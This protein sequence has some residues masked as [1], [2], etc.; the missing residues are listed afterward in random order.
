V[1]LGHRADESEPEPQAPLRAARVA[2]VKAP[3]DGL[4]LAGRHPG[5]GVAHG[6]GHRARLPRGNDRDA[7]PIGRVL[8]RIVD[9]VGQGLADPH[10]VAV[11]LGR[12]RDLDG[13]LDVLR[14]GHLPVEVGG[15]VHE[16]AHVDPL[17]PQRQDPGLR[18]RDI[19]QRL[20]QVEHVVRLVDA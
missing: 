4:A 7:A 12:A 20:Q 10:W 9:Q 18:G 15:A 1:G 19:E 13:H 8:E 6:H 11:Q 2:P 14:L 17:A 5:P 3:P 16:R